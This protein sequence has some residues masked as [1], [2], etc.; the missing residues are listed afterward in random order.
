M[1]DS[2]NA[3][4]TAASTSS[5]STSAN[6]TVQG[7]GNSNQTSQHAQGD[8]SQAQPKVADSA[9]APVQFVATQNATHDSTPS[10]V[11]ADSASDSIRT[12]DQA[13]Q[14]QGSETAPASGIN[15]ARVIQ[16]MSD[17][18][19]RVGMHSAEFGDISI[20]TSVS[21][22]QMTAQISVDHGDLGKAISAHI[23]AM[24]EKLGGES[25]LRAT[26]EVSQ[27]G[28]SFSDERGY[29]SQREAKTSAPVA[30]F[31]MNQ[32]S[33]EPDY[34]VLRATAMSAESDR[35]DIQA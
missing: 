13:F 8:G 34:P 29:S 32:G 17:T 35:L 15:T 21:M 24:Q 19:M 26:V 27:N 9:A 2:G 25:G 16:N 33:T 11:K 31:D 14:S 22:Q 28:M 18:E 6:Q 4:K 1:G 5:P 7:A 3:S 20:R 10:H 30:H 12:A 23:P